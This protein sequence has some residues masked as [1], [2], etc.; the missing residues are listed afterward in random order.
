MARHRRD[1]VARKLAAL[2]DDPPSVTLSL[3]REAVPSPTRTRERLAELLALLDAEGYRHPFMAAASSKEWSGTIDKL[4]ERFRRAT[5]SLGAAKALGQAC[6]RDPRLLAS[7]IVRDQLFVWR[8]EVDEGSVKRNLST[9]H[10]TAEEA[11]AEE[12]RRATADIARA[13]LKRFSQA[14][15]E[16]PRGTHVAAD[17][18]ARVYH[19]VEKRVQRAFMRARFAIRPSRIAALTREGLRSI[20]PNVRALGAASGYGL[21]I[22]EREVGNRLGLSRTKVRHRRAQLIPDANGSAANALSACISE[23]ATSTKRRTRRA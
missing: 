2:P 22:I 1:P 20:E 17:V 23:F 5:D 15:A 8:L 19:D 9:V 4:L 18:F 13:A 3:Q 6:R 12:K 21:E 10:L 16:Q 11:E 7:P 14:F